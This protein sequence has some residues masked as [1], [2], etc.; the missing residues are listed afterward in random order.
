MPAHAREWLPY[1]D[2]YALILLLRVAT[3]KK[4]ETR[5]YALSTVGSP[6]VI[7]AHVEQ[8]IGIAEV[9]MRRERN[10]VLRC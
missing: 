8:L 6:Q 5:R 1:L 4:F 2:V 7:D 9:G 10:Q 3:S